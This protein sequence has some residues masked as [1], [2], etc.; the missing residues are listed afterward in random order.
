MSAAAP[1]IDDLEGL[2]KSGRAETFVFLIDSAKRGA[3]YPNAS[4]YE[5]TL[6]TPLRNVFSVSLLSA[7]IPWSCYTVDVGSN[8]LAY[9]LTG[10]SPPQEVTATLTPGNYTLPTLC[11]ALSEALAPLPGAL[12]VTTLSS[13]PDLSGKVSISSVDA[14]QVRAKITLRPAGSA[15]VQYSQE[16]TVTAENSSIPLRVEWDAA[17]APTLVAGAAWE[18]LV[19]PL[20]SADPVRVFQEYSNVAYGADPP[21]DGGEEGEGLPG[22]DLAAER[23]VC[24]TVDVAQ[25]VFRVDSA[26]VC[27]VTGTRYALVRM[28]GIEDLVNQDRVAESGSIVTGGMGVVYSQGWGY[29]SQGFT[30]FPPRVFFPQDKLSKI[31]IRIEDDAGRLFNSNGINHMLQISIS[32]LVPQRSDDINLLHKL[33]QH[34]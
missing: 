32:H 28:P 34:S 18:V 5:V 14:Y 33:L 6:N 12:Q 23:V 4:D 22:T 26:G 16:A 25:G 9:R 21:V 1:Q 27:D 29:A 20:S 13:P 17:T 2:R 11:E 3:M 15:T 8:T 24:A 19:V 31:R 30:G 7:T 10:R